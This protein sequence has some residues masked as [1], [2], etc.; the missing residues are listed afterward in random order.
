MRSWWRR[1]WAAPCTLVGLSLALLPLALG[2]RARWRD[3]ALEVTWRERLLRCGPRTR[4]LPFRG[5]VF[6]QV[7]LALTA[8][9]L[10]WIGPHEHVHVE[11]YG[12]WGLL[13]FPAYLGSSLWQWLRHRDPYRDNRFE[14]QA[15]AA[16][17]PAR[18]GGA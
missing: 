14:V 1:L 17:R 12:R 9:E 8:E 2:G 7:I 13:F 11:Q 16:S 3:G 10:A 4:G 6:G 5:I 18:S 15:R